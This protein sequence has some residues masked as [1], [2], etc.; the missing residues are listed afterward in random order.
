MEICIVGAAFSVEGATR[1][2]PL[3][4]KLSVEDASPRVRK[5]AVTALQTLG[6]K[7]PKEALRLLK[8]LTQ[9]AEESVRRHVPDRI[10]EIER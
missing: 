3:T 7:L 9:D 1:A 8:N 2:I 10:A 6:A 4:V 5:S